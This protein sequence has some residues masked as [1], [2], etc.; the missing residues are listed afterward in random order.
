MVVGILIALQIN[1][2]N[3][4]R[5]QRAKR[6]SL[7]SIKVDLK[8]TKRALQQLN[9][10]REESLQNFADLIELRNSGDF[11]ETRIDTLLA[12]SMFNPT[13]NGTTSSIAVVINSGKINLLSSDSLR[14][15]ALP[16]QIENLIEREAE[17]AVITNN[18]W[19]PF[20]ESLPLQYW[21][22]NY[23]FLGVPARTG[24]AKSQ[25]IIKDYFLIEDSRT[26]SANSKF[27][28]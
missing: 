13:Y 11:D 21:F 9:I 5:K 22:K 16:I 2:A 15:M 4:A 19:M 6:K 17:A 14:A 3:E 20:A 26:Q 8:M 28:I 7:Q 23:D 1:N 27:F 12:K 18:I 24:Q 25:K 10:R